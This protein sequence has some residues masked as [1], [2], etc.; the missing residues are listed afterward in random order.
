MTFSFSVR[1]YKTEKEIT[2][3][4]IVFSLIEKSLVSRKKSHKYHL[5]FIPSNGSH[6][7]DF[8]FLDQCWVALVRT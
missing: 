1:Q 2:I 5:N 3:I 8:S 4:F 7:Q 6:L